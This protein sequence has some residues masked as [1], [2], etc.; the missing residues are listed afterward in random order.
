MPSRSFLLSD[1]A[2]EIEGIDKAASPV[3]ERAETA[4]VLFQYCSA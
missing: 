4:S 2:K 1:A 3:I